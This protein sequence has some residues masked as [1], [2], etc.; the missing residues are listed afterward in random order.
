[1]VAEM[2]LD[3][4][5]AVSGS[6][7]EIKRNWTWL[8]RRVKDK[9]RKTCN[10]LGSRPMDRE[11]PKARC[12]RTHVMF[13]HK[14]RVRMEPPVDSLAEGSEGG[15]K[16]L[17]LK[18]FT[19][20]Q[21]P[22]ILQNGTFP[23]WFQGFIS[24]RDA[25]ET[26]QD[27]ELGC[28]MIRLSD[29]AIGYIL[30]YKGRDRCRHF[31]INQS[32]T[33]QF[34]VLGDTEVHD[35]IS[36]L[37]EYY[38][39]NPIEPFGE[40]L[41]SSCG[42]TF[43]ELYDII[44][45]SPK[46]KPAATVRAAKNV[47]AQHSHSGS[48][49]PPTLPPKNS[50]TEV[51]PLPRRNVPLVKGPPDEPSDPPGKVLYAQLEKLRS[52]GITRA[53][54]SGQEDLPGVPP[55]RAERCANPSQACREE[56]VSWDSPAPR[57]GII[58]SQISSLDCKSRSL[59]LLDNS[60]DNQNSHRLSASSLTPPRLSPK[61][62][63]QPANHYALPLVPRGMSSSPAGSHSLDYLCN[64]PIYYLAGRPG[65]QVTANERRPLTPEQDN[66]YTSAEVPSQFSQTRFLLDNT[67]EQIPGHGLTREA[68][69]S[70][71]RN[72]MYESLAAP[73]PKYTVPSGGIKND[74]WK[75]F[76]PDPKKK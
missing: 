70:E 28:F 45:V 19:E 60:L 13:H 39:A 24:R 3:S 14:D 57:S 35:T 56:S 75:R 32:K 55:G 52:R 36:G 61:S 63:R 59:P 15:L 10:V 23:S 48:E 6:R 53:Q 34:I 46:E 50:S 49:K 33:K 67:Y 51:Q 74:K 68:P 71:P 62:P 58:Y 11:H 37:I 7:A 17:T 27:K 73:R 29:K 72:N 9:P 38:K 16:E 65:N 41:T 43:T 26:L 8:F 30:S 18:W 66:V 12:F 76:F 42:E 5:H 69:K 20:T 22:V 31:V 25:E 40:Y 47:Q 54:H 44:Q 21:T 64:S 2:S 1:M 4:N